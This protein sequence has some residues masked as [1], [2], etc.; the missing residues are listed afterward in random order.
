MAA[1]FWTQSFAAAPFSSENKS[2]PQIEELLFAQFQDWAR[3][4]DT[5]AFA[6]YIVKIQQVRAQS[7]L[8]CEA[9]TVLVSHLQIS[10]PVCASGQA[11]LY[12]DAFGNNLLHSAKDAA[13]VRAVDALFFIFFSEENSPI[14][15]LKNEKNSSRE[16]PL[17]AHLNR[18]N[19]DCFYPLYEGS[20]LEKAIKARANIGQDPSNL[21]FFSSREIL[22]REILEWGANAAGTNILSLVE[23]QPDS[24][25]RSDLLRFLMKN[26]P[27]LL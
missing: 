12:A 27:F 17:V 24:P 20:R 25:E 9:G 19:L 14:N 7:S 22:E 4:G 18:G 6:Q 5:S 13:T 21:L 15:R 2:K 23:Q 10:S 8:R 11:L 26:A 1:V 16:T 3:K